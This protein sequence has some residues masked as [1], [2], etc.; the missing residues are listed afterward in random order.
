AVGEDE[1]ALRE[2]E[3]DGE[4]EDEEEPLHV[5]G[6]AHPTVVPVEAAGLV[7]AEALLLVHAMA[8]VSAA[9]PSGGEIGDEQPGLVGA[10]SPDGH[11]VDV[12]PAGVLE[13]AAVALPAGAGAWGQVADGL[14]AAIR[15]LD[16][17]LALDAEQERPA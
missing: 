4:L 2:H 8:V 10:A 11:D 14:G 9:L 5:G 13:D 6:I 3:A 1:G 15:G 12:P 17:G 16:P 7:I